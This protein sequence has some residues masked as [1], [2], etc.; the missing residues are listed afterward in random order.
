VK[1]R[2]FVSVDPGRENRATMG[3]LGMPQRQESHSDHPGQQLTM[4]P[5]DDAALKATH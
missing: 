2:S 3:L 5:T 1:A 4:H